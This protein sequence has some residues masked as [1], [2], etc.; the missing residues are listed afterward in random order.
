[1]AA[2]SKGCRLSAIAAF[3]VVNEHRGFL[4]GRQ[5]KPAIASGRCARTSAGVHRRP[6]IVAGAALTA[7]GS[8]D[9][10]AA[11]TRGRTTRVHQPTAHD[12]DKFASDRRR[13][14]APGGGR[15]ARPGRVPLR[16][17][18]CCRHGRIRMRRRVLGLEHSRSPAPGIG[19]A[20]HRLSRACD[21]PMDDA[22]PTAM[23][24]LAATTPATTTRGQVAITGLQR[25]R[26]PSAASRLRT[27]R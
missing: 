20:R 7:Q 17:Q 21:S 22:N 5:E 4:I 14:A 10:R 6:R 8:R 16:R 3:K 27:R 12:C 25:Q 13:P 15:A 19:G 26:S 24:A 9:H 18:P 11:R 2:L 23:P 1:V